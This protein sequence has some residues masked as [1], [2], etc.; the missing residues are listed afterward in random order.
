M[1]GK[2]K[3]DDM[4]LVSKKKSITKTRQ[5]Q[6]SYL[7]LGF[8]VGQDTFR[9]ECVICG[10]K[11]ANDSMKPS[12]LKRHQETKHPETAGESWEYFERKK[13][14]ALSRRSTDIRRAFERAGS[15]LHRATEA[16]FECSL[17]I[18]K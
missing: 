16:S 15:D 13:K 9:P 7:D 8:M 2:Q 18:A 6:D 12:K 3:S 5:Y 17:L 4:S 10:E 11:L 14:L 1:S